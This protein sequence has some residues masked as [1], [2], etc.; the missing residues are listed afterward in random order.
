MLEPS[1]AAASHAIVG[2]LMWQRFCSVLGKH[3]WLHDSMYVSKVAR[4]AN[5]AALNQAIEEVLIAQVREL[6]IDK[7]NNAGVPCGPI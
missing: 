4:I 1:R 7:F 3:K 6:W 5:R 2:D